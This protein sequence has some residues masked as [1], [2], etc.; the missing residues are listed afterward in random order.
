MNNEGFISSKHVFDL[1]MHALIK[2]W[3]FTSVTAVS[4]GIYRILRGICQ[5]LRW[6]LWALLISSMSSSHYNISKDKFFLSY[7][8]KKK[9]PNRA[10]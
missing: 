2:P 4:R 10:T 6:K 1:S 8:N 3:N 9:L 5:I 7:N